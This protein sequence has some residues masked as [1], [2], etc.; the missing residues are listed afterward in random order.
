MDFIAWLNTTQGLEISAVV[1]GVACLVI[2]LLVFMKPKEIT[3]FAIERVKPQYNVLRRIK[4]TRTKNPGDIMLELPD[5]RKF[6]IP[7]SEEESVEILSVPKSITIKQGWRKF[8]F[9]ENGQI[10]KRIGALADKATA[11][12]DHETMTIIANRKSA[13]RLATARGAIGGNWTMIIL[14]A[15]A[16]GTLGYILYPQFNHVAPVVEYCSRMAN[17]TVSGCS[18]LP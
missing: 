12:L 17:G 15:A 14:A 10:V 2:L 6:E 3:T 13:G 9:I 4:E 8:W 18:P 1:A 7:T 5:G 16:A 11:L